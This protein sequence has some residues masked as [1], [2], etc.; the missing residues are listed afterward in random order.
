MSFAAFQSLPPITEDPRETNTALPSPS[1]SIRRP[2]ECLDVRSLDARSLIDFH[3]HFMDSMALRKLKLHTFH[4][5]VDVCQ[6]G[7]TFPGIRWLWLP[8]VHLPS[9]SAHPKQ[10][11][12]VLESPFLLT[13]RYVILKKIFW[14]G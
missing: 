7:D 1:G 5:V 13:N 14:V 4:D 12:M 10:V 6:V 8:S 3:R 11:E 2:I 9:G